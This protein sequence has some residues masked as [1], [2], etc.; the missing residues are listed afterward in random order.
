MASY[1]KALNPF[2]LMSGKRYGFKS[3]ISTDLVPPLTGVFQAIVGQTPVITDRPGRNMT[4]FSV[5]PK[6]ST[7]SKA[8]TPIANAVNAKNL[9]IGQ[10]YRV[11]YKNPQLKPTNATFLYYNYLLKFTDVEILPGVYSPDETLIDS[12]I[13]TVYELPKDAKHGLYRLG[14]N[15]STSSSSPTR[16]NL[17]TGFK[18]KTRKHK[19][20]RR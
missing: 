5:N 13:T 19:H 7:F 2:N 4:G 3:N 18:P 8:N 15:S 20:K 12:Y 1:V 14:S 9:R 17:N 16:M 10:K 6:Y 11:T